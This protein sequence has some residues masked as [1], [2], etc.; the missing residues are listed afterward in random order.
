M[1]PGARIAEAL[2][3][4]WRPDQRTP[5]TAPNDL[6]RFAPIITST[7]AG[8]LVWERLRELSTFAGSDEAAVLEET[9]RITQLLAAMQ[10]EAI[11]R[12][13]GILE[14]AGIVPL[15]FKGWAVAQ[16]YAAPSL[17]P[18]GDIDLCAPPGRYAEMATL[19]ASHAH[20]VPGS[21]LEIGES[22]TGFT[23]DFD[24][25]GQV[26]RVDLHRNLDRFHLK[27]LAD[28]FSRSQLTPIGSANIRTPS[29]EDHLRLL[30]LHFLQHGASRPIW[31]CDVSAMLEALPEDFD[32][33][34]CLGDEPLCRHW[35]TVVVAL[36]RELLD[37]RLN[38]VPA[39]FPRP[40]L[41]RWLV[42][43]VLKQWSRP[44]NVYMP[45]PRFAYVLRRLPTQIL[46]EFVARWPDPITATVSLN[47]AFD[48]KPR[49]PYQVTFFALAAWSFM[50]RSTAKAVTER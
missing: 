20:G 22:T 11:E 16:F 17:R 29:L 45:R 5:I 2:S 47:G 6:I 12:V 9:Y 30:C 10:A 1:V 42:P 40:Q 3:G 24:L 48:A 13:A 19:L 23:L 50:A 28:I 39:R 32:W 35:I 46:S 43:T 44:F 41:P 49:W 31:L 33:E 38:A 25:P 36:A 8:P 34:L 27:P 18:V 37:A 14:T 26:T 4:A 7:G 15:I 21:T